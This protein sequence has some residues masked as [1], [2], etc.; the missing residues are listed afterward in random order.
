MIYL[1]IISIS[2]TVRSQCVLDWRSIAVSAH[3]ALSC[4][5]CS[6]A[7][8]VLFP[9]G[10]SPPS[11]VNRV[12]QIQRLLGPVGLA[13]PFML[14][15]LKAPPMSQCFVPHRVPDPSLRHAYTG[16]APKVMPPIFITLPAIPAVDVG[17]M[18]VEAEPSCQNAITFCCCVT[19]GCREAV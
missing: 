16:S 8:A 10:L 15:F 17:G 9:S 6:T 11:P 14:T 18:A 1:H 12:P 5:K 7:Q 3:I 13:F 19:Q 2:R 4:L